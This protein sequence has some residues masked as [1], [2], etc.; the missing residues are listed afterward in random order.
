M[1]QISDDS[2][3]QDLNNFLRDIVNEHR[4]SRRWKI[5]FRIIYLLLLLLIIALILNTR[6]NSNANSEH[7]AVVNL[8]GIILD[9]QHTSARYINKG[10]E[11]AFQN[12]HSKAVIL[13]INSGGGSPVQSSTVYDKILALRKKFPNKKIYAVCGDA[14]AWR[15]G[16]YYGHAISAGRRVPDSPEP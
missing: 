14:C 3:Q 6:S 15:T 2:Q 12:A 13:Y 16:R 4:A 1:S 8:R 5:G 10:L 7:V 11:N 9:G